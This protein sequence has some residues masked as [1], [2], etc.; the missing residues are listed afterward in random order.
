M[1]AEERDPNDIIDAVVLEQLTQLLEGTTEWVQFHRPALLYE[2]IWLAEDH[3]VA[4]P[5]KWQASCSSSSFFVFPSLVSPCFS[6]RPPNPVPWKQGPIPT[7]LVPPPFCVCCI[8]LTG[9]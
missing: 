8:S 6:P 9:G 1:L 4:F 3:L 7:K 2:V 5:Q